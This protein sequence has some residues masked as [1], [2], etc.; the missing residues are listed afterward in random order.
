MLTTER[1]TEIY[2]ILKVKK[3]VTVNQLCDRLFVSS[4]TIRRD[5]TELEKTGLIRRSHGGAVLF[6]SAAGELSVLSRLRE[7]VREK[8]EIAKL[9]SLYIH[10]TDTLFLDPSSTVCSIVP[11]LTVFQHITVITN[12]LHC[13]M[14]LSQKTNC[15]IYIPSGELVTRTNSIVSSDTLAYIR[16]FHAD[17]ALVSCGG[18]AL[19]AGAT[20]ANVEQSRVKLS[21]L[22][23]A[24]TKIL[25]CDK[26]KFD[27]VFL[28]K[29]CELGYFDYVI[30]DQAPSE[31]WLQFFAEAPCELVYPEE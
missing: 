21:M 19:D 25:L 14:E 2:E 28:S 9:A 24:R 5:L 16:Q 13:A 17:V 23:R 27:K 31:A 30:T 1:Q 11:Y 6:E 4:A 22:R 18:L 8:S 15:K 7:R 3:A 12:G 20:E 10:D 26:S 29:T